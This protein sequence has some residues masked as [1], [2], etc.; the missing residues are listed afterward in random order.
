MKYVLAHHCDHDEHVG[1]DDHLHYLNIASKSGGKPQVRVFDSKHEALQYMK[2]NRL[3]PNQVMV[4]PHQEVIW[5]E[6]I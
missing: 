3:S 4:V 2:E 1:D 5:D 6:Q